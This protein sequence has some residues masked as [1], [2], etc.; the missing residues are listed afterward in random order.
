[1]ASSD[2]LMLVPEIVILESIQNMVKF[3][4]DDIKNNSVTPQKSFLYKLI[5]AN[6]LERYVV[7]DQVRTIF[8]ASG[9]DTRKL[10]IDLSY[11]MKVDK[12]PSIF[13]GLGSEQDSSNG[14]GLD[15]GYRDVLPENE[16]NPSEGYRYV[17][18]RRMRA[19]YVLSIHSDNN[20]EVIFLY[21]LCKSIILSIRDSLSVQGIQNLV[22]SGQDIARMSSNFPDNLFFRVLNLGFEY[23]SSSIS[24]FKEQYIIGAEFI[25]HIIEE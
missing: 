21:H 24:A 5:Q 15:Q 22:L 1:M 10:T 11:N 12:F 4:S 2:N 9:K 6:S 25:P 16:S 23:E 8:E 3:I 13:L 18:T 14:L 17:Y 7:F 20:N 19:N